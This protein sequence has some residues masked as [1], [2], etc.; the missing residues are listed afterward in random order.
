MQ[1]TPKQNQLKLNLIEGSGLARC[2]AAVSV[3]SAIG[4]TRRPLESLRC[5]VIECGSDIVLI[6]VGLGLFDWLVPQRRLG[7][8]AAAQLRFGARTSK[9]MRQ[10]LEQRGKS[11]DRVTDIIITHA[12]RDNLGGLNDFPDARLHA[13]AHVVEA[14]AT[15][16]RPP[17]Q[18]KTAPID[19]WHAPLAGATSWHGFSCQRLAL[20]AL[21][22]YLVDL[23]GHARGH[24]GVLFPT[25]LGFV[26]YL[27]D[28]FAD[29]A[30]LLSPTL[31]APLASS[32]DLLLLSQPFATLHT[33]SKLQRLARDAPVPIT[34]IAARGT[35]SRIGV[36]GR[37]YP[38][39]G[40]F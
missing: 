18:W 10:S 13:H 11:P 20:N 7:L 3:I 37:A 14:I 12:H 22:I 26:F 29:A 24:S 40:F 30:E 9:S 27:G 2:G 34:F 38:Q 35:T 39:I 25:D 1:P 8:T 4:P 28:A 23:P 15:H 6:E 5:L 16:A 36:G 31:G 32:L 19:N 17:S 21:E 33:R